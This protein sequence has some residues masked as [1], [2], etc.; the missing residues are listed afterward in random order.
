MK[1]LVFYDIRDGKR[2]HEAAKLLGKKG[3]RVQKS[4]FSCSIT[5]MAVLSELKEQL[6]NVIDKNEDKVAIYPVCDKCLDNGYYIG[7]SPLDF[8][9]TGYVIL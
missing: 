7:S 5:D 8:F 4:F 2:L 1:Y 3:K 6:G 9:D